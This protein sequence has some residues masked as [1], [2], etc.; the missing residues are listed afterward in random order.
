ML[1][2]EYIL[3]RPHYLAIGNLKIDI[4]NRVL[5]NCTKYNWL[6]H[7]LEALY[8]SVGV[9]IKAISHCLKPFV[10][11]YFSLAREVIDA[12]SCRKLF[13]RMGGSIAAKIA[14][15]G[16]C[17]RWRQFSER[18]RYMPTQLRKTAGSHFLRKCA[19]KCNYLPIPSKITYFTLY[20]IICKCQSIKNITL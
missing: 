18:W 15:I 16:S 1:I 19:H 10:V 11:L 5:W 14:E 20:V 3:Y 2:S 6:S 9:E 12:L 13:P 7:T 4:P 8:I 17:E